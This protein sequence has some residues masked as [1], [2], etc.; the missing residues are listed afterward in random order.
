MVP[1]HDNNHF[2][3]RLEYLA[4]IFQ[5]LNKVNL[6]LKEGEGQS[7]ISLTSQRMREKNLAIGSEKLK[8]EILLFRESCHGC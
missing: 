7:S 4:D 8:Q 6:K 2:I 3:S 5:Q 1:S